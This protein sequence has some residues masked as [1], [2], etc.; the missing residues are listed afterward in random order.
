[1]PS[2]RHLAAVTLASA[3]LL[4]TGCAPD[5]SSGTEAAA[6]REVTTDR[7]P[8]TIPAAPKRVVV[9]N[10]ALAGYLYKLDVPVVA[11]IPEDANATEG[12]F[13]DF[14][15]A[16]AEAEGTVFLPW[17]VDGFDLE[18]VLA[19][20]PDLIVGGGIGFP[21]AQAEQVY[22]KLTGI[23]PTVLVS[24]TLT[25]WRDQFS[26]LAEDVF[27]KGA[28]YAEYVTAYDTR[29]AE[30]R[31]SIKPPPGPVVFL[32]FTADGTAYGL[33]ESVGLPV[34]FADLGIEPAP[35]FA[36]GGFEVY[37]KGGDMFELSTEQVGKTV[38]QPTVF[39]MGFN[40]DF[41]DVATLKKNPVY[42]A[43]PAF[44]EGHAY[45]LP[46]W[47]LRGDYDEAMALLDIVA[48]RFA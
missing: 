32:A 1:M 46:Y 15:A 10:Y 48:E 4:L 33:V 20:D 34:E 36:D 37:G 35:I 3:A 45:D 21:L 42:A 9:L 23:A 16:E 18:A 27:D 7:G 5:E 11:T 43:L 12:R 8:V 40:G 22:D 30:V 47:V 24:G 17:S 19:Q 28:E 41:T 2:L 25:T 26:F 38:T 13:S 31:D 29:A 6:T 14:W 39:V 44:A